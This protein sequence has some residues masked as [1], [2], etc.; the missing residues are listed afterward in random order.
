MNKITAVI[1]QQDEALQQT[2]I[3][4]GAEKC[5]V[6]GKNIGDASLLPLLQGLDTE[7]A[8]LYM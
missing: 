7:Y 2:F 1:L 6:L 4:A 3:D 5:V 8:L